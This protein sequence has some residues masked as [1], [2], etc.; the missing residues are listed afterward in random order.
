MDAVKSYQISDTELNIEWL[1]AAL[2]H[3][4]G[5]VLLLIGENALNDWSLD[6]LSR[7]FNLSK[8]RIG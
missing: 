3:D 6:N 5:K 2:E 8:K 7:K 1:K 4:I